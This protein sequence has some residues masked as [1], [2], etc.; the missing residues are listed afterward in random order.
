MSAAPRLRPRAA[1]ATLAV[2]AL[3][4]AGC[5]NAGT[6]APAAAASAPAAALT[7]RV[8]SGIPDNQALFAAARTAL[9]EVPGGTL[10]GI[11]SEHGGSYWEA[12]VVRDDGQR[13]KLRVAADGSRIERGPRESGHGDHKRDKWRR[14]V[15]AAHL[16]YAKA[17]TAISTVRSG[18]ITELELDDHYGKVVWEADV[19]TD[20]G[21]FKVK[22][23]AGNG[24]VLDNRR[25]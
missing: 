17:G 10:V 3:F 5:G 6:S 2:T 11:E 14:R 19:R 18:H 4:M 13:V 16:D 9:A 22:I 20:D 8:A 24:A 23:D 15:E 7:S 21:K 25:D 1:T 12:K